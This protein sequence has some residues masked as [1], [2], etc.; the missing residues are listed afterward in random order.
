[1]LANNKRLIVAKIESTYGTDPT[2]T[3]SDAVLVSD[4]SITPLDSG[5]E[6]RNNI[7]PWLGSDA[8]IHVGE[9][10]SIDFKVEVAGSGTAGTAPA[11]GK[12]L[13]ACG[14]AETAT[15]DTKVEY[16]PVSASFESVTIYYNLDGQLHKLTGC[17]GTVSV[18]NQNNKIPKFAFK[19]IGKYNAPSSAS[20]LTPDFSAFQAP[21]PAGV[22][23]T[24]AFS[25]GGWSGVPLSLSLDAANDV[26]FYQTLTTSEIIIADRKAKGKLVVEAP[27]L[28]SKNLFTLALANTTAA[29]SLQHGQTAGGIVVFDAPN[30]QILKPN[31]GDA[32]G[33]ATVEMDLLL[34]PG[35]SGND[36]LKITAK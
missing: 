25:W 17:R 6:S 13:R 12:L 34:I 26:Q 18:D 5:S 16:S 3:G 21:V 9:N 2:P 7:R 10:V 22:G 28:S 32:N 8:A 29:L 4:V 20:A 14:F 23:R 27:A 36:E 1:M 33:V 24:S 31:Y 15:V 35:T 30:A 19:F 11:W